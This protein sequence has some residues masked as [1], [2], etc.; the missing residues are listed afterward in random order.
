MQEGK[1]TVDKLTATQMKNLLSN[2]I[3]DCIDYAGDSY[4]D[5]GKAIV[6]RLHQM[7][8]VDYGTSK[9]KAII[10]KY[11]FQYID[12]SL[13]DDNI[14][15]LFKA[16]DYDIDVIRDWEKSIENYFNGRAVSTDEFLNAYSNGTLKEYAERFSEN[17]HKETETIE[18]E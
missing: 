4:A 11:G 17:Y 12:C 5:F 16:C 13:E 18:R 9:E 14:K 10:E 6:K 7:K 15:L 3:E 8:L 1:K 2:I